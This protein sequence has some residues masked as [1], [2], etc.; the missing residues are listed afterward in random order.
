MHQVLSV[1]LAGGR[2]S[3]LEPL[4][5]DRAKPAVP[6]GGQY[7]IIDF[8]LSNALNSGLRR[9]YVLTQYKALSLDRHVHTA[10]SF[11]NRGLGEFIEV[12]HPQQRI[13]ENW[14]TGTADAIYQNIYSLEMERPRQ[15][16]ILGGDHI[17]RMDYR[18][19]I[20]F[21]RESRADLT[22]ACL[23][24]PRMEATRFGVL[25]AEADG[26]VT[27]FVEKPAD[28]PPMPDHPEMAL[29]SMGIYVFEAS[30]LFEQ[31][32]Q[33]AIDQDSD[34]D[35]GKNIIPKMIRENRVFRWSFTGSSPLVPGYWRDV[36]TL[37][38]YYAANMDLINVEPTFNLYDR[39]W[40]IRTSSFQDPPPKFV[41]N[42][43]GEV[44]VARRGEAHDS[45]LCAGSI[46]SGGCVE[47]SILG[48]QV[49][50]HS[51][52]HV[53]DS[54]LFD[55]V[56]VGRHAR[57]R[58]AIL[59]KDAVVPPRATIGFDH[60]ADRARGLVV[61]SEGITVVPRAEHL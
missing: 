34:H 26:R 31:L 21:H 19:M 48:R 9:M 40:P 8:V 5:R 14:Y 10:W 17:Y 22:V 2:G 54:I 24:V 39:H 35:F 25:H 13:N 27:G 50:V 4:T 15:I 37:A 52:S 18:G 51:Y 44:G 12:I 46:V 59:D 56:N 53:E 43:P 29:A 47:R 30:V 28:P 49:R 61:T 23:P 16:L 32:C 7:R 33:D 41:H 11:L 57:I 6:F 55:R 36:G 58:R 60:D 3:R 38:D 42:E 45:I 1:V 20:D